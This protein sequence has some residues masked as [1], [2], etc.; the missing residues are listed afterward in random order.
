MRP[1]GTSGRVP[2][3][4]WRDDGGR[5]AAAPLGLGLLAGLAGAGTIG[6]TLEAF[7]VGIEPFDATALLAVAAL[8]AGV[9]L[10]ASLVPSRRAARVDPLAGLRCE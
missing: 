8:L 5:P 7:L 2:R 10:V 4:R 3:R 1:T 6:R 9:A